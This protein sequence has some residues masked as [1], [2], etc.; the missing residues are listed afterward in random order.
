MRKKRTKNHDKY[1]YIDSERIHYEQE[2][3]KREA[4]SQLTVGLVSWSGG[5][6][7]GR[8]LLLAGSLHGWLRHNLSHGLRFGLGFRSATTRRMF[9]GLVWGCFKGVGDLLWWRRWQELGHVLLDERH[10][11]GVRS[12]GMFAPEVF[13]LPLLPITNLK[14]QE[15][16]NHSNVTSFKKK[17]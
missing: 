16:K 2:C 8:F 17:F 13:L 12:V 10:L 1:T 4:T 9:N 3:A 5:Q 6:W 11:L 7:S 15:K 14:L